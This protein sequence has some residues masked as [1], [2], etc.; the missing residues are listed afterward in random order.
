VILLSTF[1][2]F[3]VF[4][5]NLLKHTAFATVVWCLSYKSQIEIF[6]VIHEAMAVQAC[7]NLRGGLL[8]GGSQIFGGIFCQFFMVV[9]PF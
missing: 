1:L 6:K 8:F 3:Y 7:R 4:P 5:E 2:T 9:F